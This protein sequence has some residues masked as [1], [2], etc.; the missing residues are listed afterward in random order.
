MSILFE[1]DPMSA[2]R[3][4][5]GA[6]VPTRRDHPKVNIATLQLSQQKQANQR[7]RLCRD[8]QQRRG[9]GAQRSQY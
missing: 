7:K 4:E 2:L 8:R 5:G 9:D 3:L 1:A 6:A